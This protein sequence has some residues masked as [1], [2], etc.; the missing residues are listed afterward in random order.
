MRNMMNVSFEV[1]R[2]LLK[3]DWKL[4][5]IESVSLIL[6]KREYAIGYRIRTNISIYSKNKIFIYG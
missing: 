6:E 5:W 3:I 4:W 1:D 2:K